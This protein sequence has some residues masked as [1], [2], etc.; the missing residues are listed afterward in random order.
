MPINFNILQPVQ[1]TPNSTGARIVAQLPSGGGGGGDSGGDDGGLGDILGGLSSLIGSFSGMAGAA[2]GAGDAAASAATDSMAHSM[3]SSTTSST[4]SSMG[5]GM[6]QAVGSGSSGFNS[7]AMDNYSPIDL[8]KGNASTFGGQNNIF[9][10]VPIQQPTGSPSGPNTGSIGGS[11]QVGPSNP[12]PTKITEPQAPQIIGNGTSNVTPAPGSNLGNTFGSKPLNSSSGLASL[13]NNPANPSNPGTPFQNSNQTF[14]SK[15]I[16]AGSNTQSSPLQ[17][18]AAPKAPDTSA[19]PSIN[20]EMPNSIPNLANKPLGSTNSSLSSIVPKPAMSNDLLQRPAFQNGLE[21]HKAALSNGLTNSPKMTVVDY[22][23]PVN[24]PRM[25]VMDTQNNQMLYNAHVPDA[26]ASP[27]APEQPTLSTAQSP[28]ISPNTPFQ[29]TLSKYGADYL[30]VDK[31]GTNWGHMNVGDKNAAIPGMIGLTKGNNLIHAYNPP[32]QTM[33]G[34]DSNI[35][36]RIN[37]PTM[38]VARQ[39]P[40][41]TSVPQPTAYIPTPFSSVM[42]PKQSTFHSAEQQLAGRINTPAIP[43]VPS[44]PAVN[45]APTPYASVTNPAQ[46]TLH[47]LEQQLANRLQSPELLQ[48]LKPPTMPVARPAPVTPVATNNAGQLTQGNIDLNSRPIVHNTD[49]SI[50]TVRTITAEIDGKTVLLPT[51]INGKVVSNSAAIQHYKN[52]GENLGTFKNELD[53]NAY[54]KKMHDQ[55]GWKGN[56]WKNNETVSNSSTS[57]APAQEPY[58]SIT[59]PTVA[60]QVPD[61]NRNISASSILNPIPSVQKGVPKEALYNTA[62]VNKGLVQ[63]N[64][65][66]TSFL[67]KANPNLDPTKTAWCAGYMNSVLAANGVKGTGMLTAKSYLKY[68][69]PTTSPTKGDIVVLNRGND[70]AKGH[71]GF[72]D[73]VDYKNGTVTVLGGNQ[74]KVGAVTIKDYPLSQVAGF[75]SPPSGAEIQQQAQLNGIETP[76]QLNNVTSGYTFTPTETPKGASN[77]TPGNYNPG[78]TS[79]SK[80]VENPHPQL[81]DTAAGI[82]WVETRGNPNAYSEVGKPIPRGEHRGSRAL[83]AYQVMDYNVPAWSKEALGYPVT[84]K[85]F[86]DSPELQDQ[87]MAHRFNEQ[88]SKGVSPRDI[89]SQHFTGRKYDAAAKAGARDQVHGTTLQ[90]YEKVFNQG[91]LKHRESR[92]TISDSGASKPRFNGV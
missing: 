13:T 35:I 88:L 48:A 21:A 31:S 73:H 26:I 80:H 43:T 25:Y 82:K 45:P 33:K 15:G 50:S 83:G 52:T 23:L 68:G 7:N 2:S 70:P 65:A 75:R 3:A 74:G 90:Q 92:N 66:L 41:A 63:G 54:D 81:D 1:G 53:A 32:M 62:L 16:L 4:A 64:P 79:I 89:M 61:L 71:V 44:T 40:A 9:S 27:V 91:Y 78:V 87:I 10:P 20:K 37:A 8:G 85:Q 34:L 59:R 58:S 60:M 18:L 22:S 36:T 69:T 49:G 39:A 12:L 29:S 67:Q 14:G 24:Q 28:T 86:L 56:N 55:M 42:N 6:G 76:E 38:P 17:A 5:S 46:S 30:G 51:V 77:Y 19:V 11:G 47:P 72:V 84:P 57:K